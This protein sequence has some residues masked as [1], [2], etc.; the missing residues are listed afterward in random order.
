MWSFLDGRKIVN[1]VRPEISIFW[2][3][4]CYGELCL[5]LSCFALPLIGIDIRFPGL[6][7][8]SIFKTAV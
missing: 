8:G 3:L 1:A 4:T 2:D 6:F 5:P 7:A